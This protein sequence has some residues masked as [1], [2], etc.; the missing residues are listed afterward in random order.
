MCVCA[1]VICTLT[2]MVKIVSHSRTERSN[3]ATIDDHD[4]HNR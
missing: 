1:Y 4:Q 2:T 3:T